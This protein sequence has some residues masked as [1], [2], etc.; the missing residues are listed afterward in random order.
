MELMFL[1]IGVL[2]LVL[3]VLLSPGPATLRRPVPLMVG[4][5]VA[6]RR[7]RRRQ[8]SSRSRLA[9]RLTRA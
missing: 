6:R 5:P 3:L 4:H 2:L 8:G 1:V 7:R 9:P